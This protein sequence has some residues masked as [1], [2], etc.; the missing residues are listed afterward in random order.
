MNLVSSFNERVGKMT[1]LFYLAVFGLMVV[2]VVMRYFL[3]S[4]TDWGLELMIALAGIHYV[5]SG[6]Q[7][8]KNN[9]HV[10]V[11]VI[12]LLLPRRIRLCM[13][14]VS[15]LLMTTFLFILV[16]YASAQAYPA[17]LQG[18]RTGAGWN[19]LA[20]TYMK[21][22][23]AVGAVMMVAQCLVCLIDKIKEIRHEW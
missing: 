22:A 9:T 17:V 11:D 10:R 20:P 12:Y 21:V 7:A 5:L 23:I 3:G 6:A 19:S 2:E 15:Y 14:V 13:D 16:Y 18:E 4:G 1:A 8:I